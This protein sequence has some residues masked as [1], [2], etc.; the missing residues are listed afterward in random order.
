MLL[1][2]ALTPGLTGQYYRINYLA[3]HPLVTADGDAIVT[4]D[5]YDEVVVMYVTSR[6]KMQENDFQSAQNIMQ[7]IEDRI[8]AI[9][10]D[11]SDHGDLQSFQ[12]RDEIVPMYS[13][14]EY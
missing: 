9:T 14:W 3:T 5:E 1:Y 7:L 6:C 13:P 2:P 10:S 8:R 11:Y 4:P 12:V